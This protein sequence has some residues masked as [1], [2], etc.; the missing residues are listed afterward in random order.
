MIARPRGCVLRKEIF[1]A[2]DHCDQ[3]TG[4]RVLLEEEYTESD[5]K[6]GF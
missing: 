4:F 5:S 2:P 6:F 3:F 1:L